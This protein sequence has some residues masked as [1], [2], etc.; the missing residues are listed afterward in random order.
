MQHLNKSTSQARH[1]GSKSWYLHACKLVFGKT[2][3]RQTKDK[4]SC[5]TQGQGSKG[6][7]DE[8]KDAKQR[9][10]RANDRIPLLDYWGPV[11]GLAHPA[12]GPAANGSAAVPEPRTAGPCADP[13]RTAGFFAVFAASNLQLGELGAFR[14]SWLD[15]VDSGADPHIM[16]CHRRLSGLGAGARATRMWCWDYLLREYG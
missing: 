11:P 13:G 8:L 2:N 6:K 3:Q 5:R 15:L 10:A 14:S 4:D 12:A 9:L 1:Q 7:G 16:G